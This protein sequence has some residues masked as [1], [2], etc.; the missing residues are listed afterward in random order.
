[1]RGHKFVTFLIVR[2]VWDRAVT[3]R[4]LGY[5]VR[6]LFMNPVCTLGVIYQHLLFP[7]WLLVKQVVPSTLVSIRECFLFFC[8]FGFL[9]FC[10]H[11]IL[12]YAYS[13][14]CVNNIKKLFYTFMFV[15]LLFCMYVTIKNCQK[16]FIIFLYFQCL[17]YFAKCS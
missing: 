9:K 4:E 11:T 15:I 5:F 17:V 16:L 8:D 12:Y 7:A 1:M 13:S 10:C 14:V 6:E 2:T 3:L